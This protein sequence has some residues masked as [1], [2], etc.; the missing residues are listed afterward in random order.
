M[1]FT[2]NEIMYPLVDIFLDNDKMKLTKSCRF[3]G[4]SIDEILRRNHHTEPV[5]GRLSKACC[6]L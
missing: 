3:S 2:I 5:C 6:N 1:L 4:V